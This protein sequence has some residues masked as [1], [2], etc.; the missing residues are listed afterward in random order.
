MGTKADFEGAFELV[1]SGRAMP[2]VDSVYP[3]AETAAAHERLESGEQLG[4]VVLRIPG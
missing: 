2:V 3:L 4:K 1:K